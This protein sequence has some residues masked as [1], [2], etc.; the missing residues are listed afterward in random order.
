MKSSYYYM[1]LIINYAHSFRVLLDSLTSDDCTL[2]HGLTLTFGHC[3][4]PGRRK[5]ILL[6]KLLLAFN[7]VAGVL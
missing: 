7:T 4:C 5:R 1:R 3:G 6:S 2:S